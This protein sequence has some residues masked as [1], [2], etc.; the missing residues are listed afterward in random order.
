MIDNSTNAHTCNEKET[1]TSLTSLDYNL[2]IIIV[3]DK[4]MPEGIGT[5]SILW[6][7]DNRKS[8]NMTIKDAYFCLNSPVNLIGV[9]KL[10]R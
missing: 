9:T 8:H 6:G 2:G 4:A 3:G 5:V 7:D 1:F 10:A